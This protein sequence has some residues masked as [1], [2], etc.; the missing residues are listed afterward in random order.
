ML[1]AENMG[2]LIEKFKKWKD[3]EG[4]SD[5]YEDDKNNGK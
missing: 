2:K 5:E 4:T 3:M 1:I